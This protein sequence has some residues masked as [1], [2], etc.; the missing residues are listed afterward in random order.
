MRVGPRQSK[1]K[2]VNFLSELSRVWT[3]CYT[4]EAFSA[5]DRGK[6]ISDK[7]PLCQMVV[8][9]CWLVREIFLLG[10]EWQKRRSMQMPSSVRPSQQG[11]KM[12]QQ[13]VL[14]F[15]PWFGSAGMA[16]LFSATV[17]QWQAHFRWIINAVGLLSSPS[18]LTWPSHVTKDDYTPSFFFG[19][20]EQ[21]H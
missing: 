18:R 20:S 7:P 6:Q 11:R 1:I 12:K 5:G 3:S 19:P 8:S 14:G 15:V 21:S 10:S 13:L 4:C 16:D 17:R 9:E 2:R